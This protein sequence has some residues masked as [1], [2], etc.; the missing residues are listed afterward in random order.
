MAPLL[1]H[2][3]VVDSSFASHTSSKSR[4]ADVFNEVEMDL[5]GAV[6]IGDLRER[7]V[8][9]PDLQ[10]ADRWVLSLSLSLPLSPSLLSPLS[11]ARQYTVV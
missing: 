7:L 3:V 11:S 9:M 4:L 10:E 1:T 8:R 2:F 5:E 6:K